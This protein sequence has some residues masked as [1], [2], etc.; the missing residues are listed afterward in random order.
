[1]SSPSFNG[2]RAWWI[3]SFRVA[4]LALLCGTLAAPAAPVL[5]AE[6]DE[7][8][9]A[10]D[11]VP[12]DASAFSMSLKLKEQIEIVAES[13]AWKAYWKI[14]T[15]EMGWQMAE[16]QINNP[17]GPAAMF[18]QLMELPENQQL[19]K[20][21][22][23]MFS[24]E[25][26][27][28]AG[29]D[30]EKTMELLSIFQ[31]SRFAP[32]LAAIEGD[33]EAGQTAQIEMVL[34]AI[35]E[36]PALLNVPDIVF[37]FRI[38]DKEAATTQL[39]RLEVL[40]N[41]ALQLSPLD[42]KVEREEI[43]ESEFIVLK[44]DGT[45][46]PWE[47]EAPA[48]FPL[49]EE[50]YQKLKETVSEKELVIALGEWNGY[51]LVS[52]GNST[53]HVVELG[54]GDLLADSEE[55]ERLTEH[56]K[57]EVVGVQYVSEKLMAY[58]YATGEDLDGFAA[59]IDESLQESEEVPDELKERISKD[60]PE[61]AKDFKKYLPTPGAM[62]GCTL[63]T[64]SG[65]ESF[66][67]SWADPGQLDASKPLE[68]TQ[69]LGGSPLIA[70]AARGKSDPED[71]EVLVKWVGKGIGY[72]EDFAL[73]QM[74]DDERAKA[75][76]A[77]EIARP[78]L[79]RLNETT[80]EHLVPALADGQSAIVFDADIKAK[81][82]H[83]EMSESHAELPMLEFGLALGVSE[84]DEF[85]QAMREYKEI[86]DD[87][88][89]AIRE[90]NPEAIPEDYEIP[91]PE[92][93]S[94]SAGTLYTW[95]LSELEIDDQ[96]AVCGGVSDHIAVLAS[97][98]ALAER[99]LEEKP[100]DSAGET[101]G[102]DEEPRAMLAGIDFAALVDA[103]APWVHYAIR[104]NAIAEDELSQDPEDDPQQ[105][106]DI[107]SQVQ[108]GLEILK[109]FR[110]AWGE[111]REDDGVWVTHTVAVFEDLEDADE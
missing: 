73:E 25:I 18:W 105:V 3:S 82:W 8:G 79:K 81:K 30:F 84:V 62:V 44:L 96:I 69:H 52:I 78:L 20:L 102:G 31:G 48:G 21:L 17:D 94:T 87:A 7:Y 28:Y 108:S 49:D 74:E 109:C 43:G 101:L 58:Q 59:M 46:I 71:Y 53:E 80:R 61:L 68:I 41:M 70:V 103:A 60:L 15:I 56:L 51:L 111:T 5:A 97:S 42:A 65:Y 64:A 76:K 14:P 27:F 45:M 67:Y 85:M 13:N 32:M 72:F 54:N 40:A 110:G 12:A 50:S 95:S 106:Q 6:E 90:A 29:A 91:E 77:L 38:E 39:K 86:A 19:V 107:C 2:R 93:A 92:E 55:F 63:L 4:F 11:W 89:D 24:D 36:D 104:A 34:E 10:L 57:E 37:A 98:P 75:E 99:V 100:L 26:A 16:M 22:G 23:Q 88:V 35:E 83:E 1:M 9:N 33:P 66:S 47:D